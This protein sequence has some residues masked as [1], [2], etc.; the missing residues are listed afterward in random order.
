MDIVEFITFIAAMLLLLV[1]S[2][3]KRQREN[4]EEVEA[5]D[6]LQAVRLRE[7]LQTV[8]SDMKE[9]SSQKG[10]SKLS[11]IAQ[12]SRKSQKSKSVNRSPNKDNRLLASHSPI[13]EPY[14]NEEKAFELKVKDAYAFVKP[15]NS[16]AHHF[17]RQLKN[18][19]EMILLHEIIGPPKALKPE[20][21]YGEFPR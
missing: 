16:R 14:A 5:E 4:P 8:N 10:S 13:A 9:S 18:P 20:G 6:E 15:K 19:K 21:P 17:I 3:N 7:F 2:R 1:S 12:P 11:Q